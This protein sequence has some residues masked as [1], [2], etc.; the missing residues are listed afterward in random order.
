MN[1]H[2]LN[3]FQILCKK[4][5]SCI[6]LSLVGDKNI[7][8]IKSDRIFVL[9]VKSMDSVIALFADK[10]LHRCLRHR[11]NGAGVRR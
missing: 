7:T 1:L 8:F 9:I 4:V 11:E 5:Y 6:P 10:G 3:S 2:Y